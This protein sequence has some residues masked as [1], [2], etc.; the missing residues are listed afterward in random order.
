MI[1]LSAPKYSDMLKFMVAYPFIIRGLYLLRQ[2][3]EPFYM[4]SI[5]L[6]DLVRVSSPEHWDAHPI[7]KYY[8]ASSNKTCESETGA[9]LEEFFK[10]TVQTGSTEFQIFYGI[11]FVHTAYCTY[12]FLKRLFAGQVKSIT[13]VVACVVLAYNHSS[14][15]LLLS[16]YQN[17]LSH[18]NGNVMHHSN[19]SIDGGS[20]ATFINTMPP[21]LVI[22]YIQNYFALYLMVYFALDYFKL[23]KWLYLSLGSPLI[24][25]KIFLQMKVIHPYVHAEQKSWYG[26]PIS[27][28]L[29]DDY[30]GHVLCHHVN[31]YCLGDSPVYS[32]FYDVIMYLHGQV[33]QAGL[34]QFQTPSY[35]A[36]SMALDY[37]LLASALVFVYI[38]VGVVSPFMQ[39][40]TATTAAAAT[41]EKTAAKKKVN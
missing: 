41:V 32:K 22:N 9:P 5:C 15:L 24:V 30:K 34:L 25:A 40:E 37:L 10:N 19:F 16:H 29:V 4:N 26:H 33:F 31:G 12:C 11:L 18:I 27:T 17:D 2:S 1:S 3:F 35:Y 14:L 36:A 8:T 38:T 21:G 6:L 28:Y 20:N 23:D 39:K 7:W 13:A